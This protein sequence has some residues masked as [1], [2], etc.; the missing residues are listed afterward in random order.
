VN[1][2]DGRK[3]SHEALEAYRLRAIEL[4]KMGKQVKKI[5]LFFWVGH[6]K[7]EVFAKII[8]LWRFI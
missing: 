2:H 3:L 8:S 4:R 1:I 6:A 7:T 5:D